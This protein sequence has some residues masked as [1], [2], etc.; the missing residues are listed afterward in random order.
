[1][2]VK[3]NLKDCLVGITS[4]WVPTRNQTK[5]RAM[6]APMSMTALTA[7]PACRTE[8]QQLGE[9]FKPDWSGAPRRGPY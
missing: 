9:S 3:S 8:V 5:L 2:M 7:G 1:M 4:D 6:I